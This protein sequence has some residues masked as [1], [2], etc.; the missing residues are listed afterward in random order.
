M[1]I[2]SLHFKMI[3]ISV[4]LADISSKTLTVPE[5]PFMR[6]VN[7]SICNA[8]LYVHIYHKIQ[9]FKFISTVYISRYAHAHAH[10]RPR[11]MAW[12]WK[13]LTKWH[14]YLRLFIHTAIN[15]RP[16]TFK[17]S[18]KLLPIWNSVSWLYF[19]FLASACMCVCGTH[20]ERPLIW[21]FPNVRQRTLENTV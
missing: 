7:E 11:T 8:R 5:I 16:K 9:N 12:H 10:T 3:Y 17:R 20:T 14:S 15:S 6:H 1:I 4:S 21:S 18:G 19:V 2:V 13:L